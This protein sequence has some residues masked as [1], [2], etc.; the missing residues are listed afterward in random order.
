MTLKI[1]W[2][3]LEAQSKRKSFLNP[4]ERYGEEEVHGLYSRVFFWWINSYL[5]LGFK[6]VLSVDDLPHL[7]RTMSVDVL[8]RV[9]GMRWNRAW[10]V[11]HEASRT[12]R[13]GL[14]YSIM[15]TFKSSVI[16]AF[17]ARLA[18]IGLTYAQPFLI[19]ALTNYVQVFNCLYQHHNFRLITKIRGA[20]V[21]S[22]FEKTLNLKFDEYSDTAAL[23]LM[24]NVVDNIAFGVQN[25]HEVWANP[26]TADLLYEQGFSSYL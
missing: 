26:M 8:H 16:C 7:D 3:Y 6:H 5:Y 9:L 21:S 10:S 19:M 12:S 18:V 23:I 25:M 22:I 20:I 4:R 24:S 1:I 2:F 13:N 17:M 15:W 14:A 11:S